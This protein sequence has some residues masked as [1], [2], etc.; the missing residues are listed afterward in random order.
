MFE[1]QRSLTVNLCTQAAKAP[2]AAARRGGA[3]SPAAK[4]PAGGRSPAA[5]TPAA[6]RRTNAVPQTE[7]SEYHGMLATALQQYS[8]SVLPSTTAAR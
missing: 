4:S 1:Y 3:A 5:R 2:A 6:A 7:R 8:A